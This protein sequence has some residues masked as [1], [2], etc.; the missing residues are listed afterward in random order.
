[1]TNIEYYLYVN[2]YQRLDQDI[3]GELLYKEIGKVDYKKIF[4]DLTMCSRE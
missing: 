1:M 3:I 4:G 2:P